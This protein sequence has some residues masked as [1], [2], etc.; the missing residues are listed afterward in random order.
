MKDRDIPKSAKVVLIYVLAILLEFTIVNAYLAST[1]TI[2][3]GI[4]PG[5]P[6]Y[7][8]FKEGSTYYAKDV[9]GEIRF[10]GT[11]ASYVFNT[12]LDSLPN[13]GSFYVS[14]GDYTLTHSI[15]IKY[16]HVTIYG[17]GDS[18]HLETANDIPIIKTAWYVWRIQIKDLF[19]EGP[20]DLGT[21]IEL[22]STQ[23]AT[24]ERNTIQ[25]FNYGIYVWGNSANQSLGNFITSNYLSDNEMCH[26]ML[27]AYSSDTLIENNIIGGSLDIGDGMIASGSPVTKVNN[28]HFWGITTGVYFYRS[29]RSEANDNFFD[30]P[31]GSAIWVQEQAGGAGTNART[32]IANNIIKQ[33]SH[34]ASGVSSSILITNSTNVLVDGNYVY[35]GEDKYG[36]EEDSLSDYNMVIASSFRE[37]VTAGIHKSGANTKVNLCWNGT[38]WIP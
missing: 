26:V 16:H 29:D 32:V 22:F 18:S 23:H 11:N 35:G 13:G 38:N 9:Y 36:L 37:S 27:A 30:N 7:T 28:N 12:A 4:Y 31:T 17:A 5:A 6:S 10:S 21:G 14:P 2:S 3:S 1:L 15:V 24:V 33:A 20:R 34:G 8:F 25:R 19:L